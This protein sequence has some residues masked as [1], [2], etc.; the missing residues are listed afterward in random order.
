MKKLTITVDEAVYAGLQK[1]V[2]K[3]NISKFLSDLARPYVIKK[4]LA[5]SYKEMSNDKSREEDAKEWVN[6]LTSEF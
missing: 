5:N 2:G 1:V 6:N 4:E 3:G